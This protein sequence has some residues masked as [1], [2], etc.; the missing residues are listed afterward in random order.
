MIETQLCKLRGSYGL[1]NKWTKKK[2]KKK[3]ENLKSSP[4]SSEVPERFRLNFGIIQSN[5][6][7]DNS[8]KFRSSTAVGDFIFHRQMKKTSPLHHPP[9]D[10]K[11]PPRPPHLPPQKQTRVSHLQRAAATKKWRTERRPKHGRTQQL[12]RAWSP[13]GECPQG[14]ISWWW[15]AAQRVTC[16]LLYTS[17]AADE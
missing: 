11:P 12:G 1:Y 2:R 9:H 5:H 4:D 15:C 17:D 6:H 3:K 10:H 13:A 16:C 8:S 7:R 14:F